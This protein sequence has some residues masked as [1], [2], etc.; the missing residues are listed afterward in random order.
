MLFRRG[1]AD[2]REAFR[3]RKVT[4]ELLALLDTTEFQRSILFEKQMVNERLANR[5]LVPIEVRCR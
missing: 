2:M 1:A 4:N 5:N 3:R